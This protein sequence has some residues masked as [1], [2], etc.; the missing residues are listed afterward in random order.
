MTILFDTNST[1]MFPVE[2]DIAIV[3]F[4]KTLAG[5]KHESYEF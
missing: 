3:Q 5:K 4:W 2:V 1:S